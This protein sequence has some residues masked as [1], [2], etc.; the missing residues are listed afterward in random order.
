MHRLYYAS[1]ISLFLLLLMGCSDLP[2]LNSTPLSP[3]RA[4]PSLSPT[5]GFAVPAEILLSANPHDDPVL[6]SVHVPQGAYLTQSDSVGLSGSYN[7]MM[8]GSLFYETFVEVIDYEGP[9]ECSVEA[10]FIVEGSPN[11]R[12]LIYV[13]G[14]HQSVKLLPRD[15]LAEFP[16]SRTAPRARWFEVI[17]S[18]GSGS[19]SA[20]LNAEI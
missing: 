16:F 11:A 7:G 4:I 5:P 10:R 19:G 14:N 18:V 3:D 15:I 17:Q 6:R 13:H 1:V 2:G 12:V 20:I 9:R 8:S